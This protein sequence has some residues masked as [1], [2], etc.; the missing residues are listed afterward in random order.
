MPQFF[1]THFDGKKSPQSEQKVY[2]KL[3]SCPGDFDVYHSVKWMRKVGESTEPYLQAGEVD[4]VI[5]K[6]RQGIM[7]LEVKG[8]DIDV[9]GSKLFT[10]PFGK[11][12]RH[13]IDPMA[14]LHRSRRHYATLIRDFANK[15]KDKSKRFLS[16]LPIA[17]GVCFPGCSPNKHTIP[18]FESAMVID[19]DDLLLD[20]EAFLKK[21]NGVFA[22]CPSNNRTLSENFKTTHCAV[23]RESVFF[24]RFPHFPYAFR[25]LQ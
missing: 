10:I 15:S 5:V 2:D 21:L 22:T 20:H 12:E 19:H 23:L 8:G 6:P 18:G 17:M 25:L 7:L 3:R 1:P 11:N 9:E 4:F 14:Q 24:P 16:N 13:E